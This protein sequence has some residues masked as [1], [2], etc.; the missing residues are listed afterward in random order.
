MPSLLERLGSW[1]SG[2]KATDAI[3]FHTNI[4]G[5]Y[6]EGMGN[7][8]SHATLLQESLGVADIATRAIAN[9]VST[10]NP[11]VKV[12]R[13]VRAGTEVEEILDD[14]P[15]KS[16][17]D[18]PHPDLSRAQLLRLTAQWIVTVGEAYWLKVGNGFG[19]PVELHPIPPGR[20]A[21]RFAGG[22]V[23]GYTALNGEGRPV[24]LDADMV[25]RFYF[26]DPEDHHYSE[27]HYQNDA[28]PKTYLK[29][30][31]NAQGFKD[32]AE[33]KAFLEMWRVKYH[34]PLL[35]HWRDEELMAYGTPRS[36]LGQVVSGDRSSAETNQYVFDRH[37]IKPV[38]MLISDSLTL[39]LAYDF[40]SAL[41]VEF[42][43]FVSDDKEFALKQEQSDLD[44]KVRSINMVLEDRN[45]DTVG[46]GELPVG[47]LGQVPYDGT[48]D[49]DLEPDD[50]TAF[51]GEEEEGEEERIRA[52]GRAAFFTPQA[53][54]LR[55]VKREKK[56]VPTFVRAMRAIFRDQLTSTLSNL[57]AQ[58]PRARIAVETIFTPEEWAD[59][60]ERRVEPIREKAFL[61][62]ANESFA[63]LGID[64]EFVLTD[65][66]REVL[67]EQGA[68]LIKH[69]NQT[70]KKLIAGQLAEATAEGEG[71]DQIAKR[72][73]QVFTT[74]RHHARTIARTEVLKSSQ[75]AQIESFEQSGV[76]EK[77]Q[78]NTSM[79]AAVRDEHVSVEGQTVGLREP[80]TLG[81][82][83]QADAPGIG[84]GGAPLTP[85]NS[86]NCR[87]FTTPVLEG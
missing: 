30:G 16:M 7:Q 24:P 75:T 84:M 32:E 25:I 12:K 31:P 35:E 66:M 20:V 81:N 55:Q 27:S 82:G 22:V 21:P 2:R 15:L 62:T 71:V 33:K 79:D 14:H 52:K 44:R 28:T 8:P 83:E 18:R 72:I 5:Y 85:G 56:Y 11:Q 60:F 43:E 19:L 40:D 78:W 67:K 73:R 26:P 80:F 13:R 77:K 70:T 63:G 65:Q 76:V 29:P 61:A 53:E 87:C 23:A 58:E 9:R 48:N 86:I 49:F 64:A 42:E 46:W 10:L 69:A 36:I 4:A 51:G 50:E 68:Q 37:T 57:E 59:L 41:F 34:Q 74:R 47:Q 45:K 6:G 3:P 1:V 39:Q 17:L 38:A 54:W